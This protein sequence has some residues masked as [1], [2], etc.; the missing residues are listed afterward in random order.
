[1]T[2][3]VLAGLISALRALNTTLKNMAALLLL[4]A[5]GDS[6]IEYKALYTA[7]ASVGLIQGYW[8]K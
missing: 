7:T 5:S 8:E 1:M 4:A 3:V 2:A 6:S